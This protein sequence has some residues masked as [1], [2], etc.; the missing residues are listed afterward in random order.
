MRL[1]VLKETLGGERR[2]AIAPETV[3]LLVR[4]GLEVRVQSGAGLGA[5]FTDDNYIQAGASVADDAPGAVDGADVVVAI[6]PP[7]PEL[8][9][10]GQTLICL[11]APKTNADL[12]EQLAAA[13][14]TSFALDAMPRITRAQAMDVLSSQ[15]TVAGYRAVLLAAESLSV[16]TPMLMT[17]AG[18]I[19]PANALV[20]GAGVAGLQAVATAR[21]LGAVVTAV[22]VRPAA[23]EQVESLGAK[24]IPMEVDHSAQDAGGYAADLGEDF[25][26][27]EQDIIAPATKKAD[28]II[29]TALIPNRPAPTLITE[30]MVA[31]MKPGAVI[32]DLAA[33]GGGNCSPSRPGETVICNNVTIHAPLNLPSEVPVDASK[34]FSSNVAAFIGE[35][36]NDAGELNID[37]KNEIVKGT[38]ITREGK[39]L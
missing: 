5:F 26:R 30:Q 36:L 2:V 20:I 21:R 34:M 18:T 28:F 39:T 29:T 31:E 33:P 38:L 32:V 35:L 7:E 24:F 13:G 16:M 10:G 17:A 23:R 27:A 4:R 25:Y 19:R 11:L 14:V 3:A 12:I 37:M 22:D 6:A 1:A 15:S 9:S 8:L